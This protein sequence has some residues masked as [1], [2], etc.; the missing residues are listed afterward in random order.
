MTAFTLAHL[1]DP[2]L[3]PMPEPEVGELL[4]KRITGYLNWRRRRAA[5]HSR[6]V[7]DA[8][9]ADL[10]AQKPDHI[11]ITGDLVNISLSAEFPPARTWLDGLGASANVTIVPGNHDVYVRVTREAHLQAWSP[12]M[13]GDGAAHEAAVTFPFLRR[14]GPVAILGLSSAVP[15]PPFFAT[16]RIGAAQLARLDAMLGQIG[17]EHA[18][19]IVLIHHPLRSASGDWLKRLVDGDA[20]CALLAR[21]GVELVLHGHDHRDEILWLDHANLATPAIGVPSA[22]AVGDADHD[23]AACNYY[24]IAK[25]RSQ[26]VCELVVRGWNGE[27]ITELR[28][29]RLF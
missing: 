23:A 10:K 15:T 19:R 4:S 9:V 11:A 14:R 3:S 25:V 20:L 28:R 13:T 7:L 18:F 8:L 22:S 6:K 5:F 1:S 17:P 26:W 2:H 16:G 29:T 24:R 27:R 21:H 12:F